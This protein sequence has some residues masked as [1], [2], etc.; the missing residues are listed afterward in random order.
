METFFIHKI[1]CEVLDFSCKCIV[2]YGAHEPN[3]NFPV[4]WLQLTLQHVPGSPTLHEPKH[5]IGEF[6]L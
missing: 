6:L 2:F 4:T 1:Y 5:L 3:I